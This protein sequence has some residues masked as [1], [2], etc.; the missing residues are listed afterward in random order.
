MSAGDVTFTG[1][2]NQDTGSGGAPVYNSSVFIQEVDGTPSGTASIIIVPNGTITSV[3]GG[4][5]TLNFVAT[6][7][8]STTQV[9][10]N[11]AGV[12]GASANFAWNNTDNLLTLAGTPG[13]T[14]NSIALVNGLKVGANSATAAA[15]GAGSF[16]LSGTA[17][18]AS[19]G[20]NWNTLAAGGTVTSVGV[21]STDFSVSG[22]PVTTSGNITLNINNDAVT[23][24]KIQNVTTNRLLGR[25]TAG[26]GDVEEITLGTGLSYT[27]TTLNV[28]TTGGTVTSV[29]VSGGSTGLTTSGGPITTSGTITLAGT[30]AIANGGT[31]QTTANPAFN[32]LAPS[33]TSNSG[34]FLT[35]NGTDTS[36][37]AVSATPGGS[38]TNIQFNNTSAFDGDGELTWDT[39]GKNFTANGTSAGTVSITTPAIG[40][41]II[42]S[43]AG[44]SSIV[45]I[46]ATGSGTEAV[47]TNF[48][49][50][51]ESAASSGYIRV[52]PD[53]VATSGTLNQR[54]SGILGC[55]NASS[56]ANTNIAITPALTAN[57]TVSNYGDLILGSYTTG[58]TG[59]ITIAGQEG[60]TAT[61]G[62]RSIISC[63]NTNTSSSAGTITLTGSGGAVI[64]SSISSS[65]TAASTISSTGVNSYVQGCNIASTSGTQAITSTGANSAILNTT[66]TGTGSITASGANSIITGV[67][68]TSSGAI[69][70]SSTSSIVLACRNT[71]S[72]TLLAGPSAGFSNTVIGLLV[73]TNSSSYGITNTNTSTSGVSIVGGTN[74]RVTGTSNTSN[75]VIV[76]GSSNTISGASVGAALLGGNINTASSTGAVVV[77]GSGNTAS[78]TYSAVLAGSSNTAS[79]T[80]SI[81]TGGDSNQAS[82]TYSAVLGGSNNIANQTSSAVLGGFTNTASGTYAA[83]VGGTNNTCSSSA[84]AVLAGNNNSNSGSYSAVIGG[85]SNTTTKDYAVILGGIAGNARHTAAV[86]SG[87]NS[88]ENCQRGEYGLLAYTTDA[89]PT[90][91]TIANLAASTS[92]RLTL[93]NSEQWSFDISVVVGGGTTTNAAWFHIRGGIKRGAT[94]ASTTIIGTNVSE[95]GIDAGLAGIACVAQADTTNGAL[96]IMVTGLAATTLG[97]GAYVKAMQIIY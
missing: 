70:A 69:T 33:Q 79:G 93:Q 96:Q 72:S 37:A 43:V 32:A 14:G 30:L 48:I 6:P 88:S 82:A 54:A 68:S 47:S 28:S 74:N 84:S 62:A 27:G 76:G 41:A 42:S 64:A 67:T 87:H 7:A 46:A 83:V 66:H 40:S 78:G 97:W 71:S 58:T 77:G 73:S 75:S 2:L 81:I 17:V 15:A 3:A 45:D 12:L 85:D 51:S 9:Q 36:W 38:T 53:T 26:S 91:L 13:S 59:Y 39:T 22:S 95:S 24:A 10:F 5:A 92:T 56:G 25:A 20:T 29:A 19:D 61:K 86:V 23:Y 55:Y 57:V 90:Q 4:T 8:G 1:S 49:L 50:G 94:A 18:Q 31:G 60:T 89:T 52:R 63:F 16:R 80:N 21:A 35:T 11:N 44:T 34:K 65:G